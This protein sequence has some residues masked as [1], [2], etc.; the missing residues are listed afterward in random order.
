MCTINGMT[1]RATLYF[2][3]RLAKN[4]AIN[5]ECRLLYRRPFNTFISTAKYIYNAVTLDNVHEL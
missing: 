5:Q 2:A 1:F 4:P 3:F